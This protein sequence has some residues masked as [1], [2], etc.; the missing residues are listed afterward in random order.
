MLKGLGVQ[1]AIV[2][3]NES[4]KLTKKRSEEPAGVC[5]FEDGY[6]WIQVLAENYT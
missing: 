3:L 4:K 1:K 6:Q 5:G 2:K